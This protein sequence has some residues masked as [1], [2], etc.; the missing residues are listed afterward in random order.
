[1]DQRIKKFLSGLLTQG[2]FQITFM[3]LQIT[4]APLLIKNG[5]S[6]SLG[7]YASIMQIVG[8][9]TLLDLGF[10]SMLSRYLSQSFNDPVDGKKKFINIF[11]IGRWYL[12]VACAI[13]GLIIALLS[14][15]LPSSLGLK[16]YL[17]TD[18][19]NAMIILAIWYCIRYYFT[20]F[21]IVLYATQN[22]KV[23]NICLTIGICLRFIL[24][25]IFI[26]LHYGITG[27]VLANVIGDFLAAFSQMIY[28]KVKNPDIKFSWKI[29]DKSVFKQLFSFGIDSFLINIATR[30][31]QSSTVFIAGIMVGAVSAGH[32]YSMVTP[33]MMMFTYINLIMYNLLPGMNEMVI[34]EEWETLRNLYLQTLKSKITILIAAFWGLILFHKYIVLVWVGPSQYE[35]FYFTILLAFYMAVVT[36]ASLNENVLIVLGTIRWYARLQVCITI[37]GLL[38]TVLGGYF[39]GLKGIVLGNLIVLTPS[40][41]YVFYRLAKQLEI[42]NRLKEALPSLKYT[43]IISA[44]SVLI[45]MADERVAGKMH[46]VLLMF[47]AITYLLILWFTGFNAE[48]RKQ[49]LNIVKK[50]R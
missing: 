17:Q 18:A 50:R 47:T 26:K 1:M 14:F 12:F 31:F 24:T 25:L 39:F 34:K 10:T 44:V 13:M 3:V 23:A 22:M 32:Y 6:A 46:L 15:I 19:R 49:T 30:A 9:L 28:F 7:G 37:A 42:L 33:P 35:G 5:G 21:N 38:L 20:M 2:L 4:I 43:F 40:S 16:G 8:Y 36:L 45:L 29:Y 41:C 48:Q 11:N 27:I